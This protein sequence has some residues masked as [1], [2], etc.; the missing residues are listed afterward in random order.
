MEIF[1]VSN[2]D[3]IGLGRLDTLFPSLHRGEKNEPKK[4]SSLMIR[5]PHSGQDVGTGIVTDQESLRKIPDTLHYTP[6]P[7]CGFDHAWWKNEAW[8]A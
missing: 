1:G 6:C 3:Q 7:Y 2:F 5:C 8:L 4:K